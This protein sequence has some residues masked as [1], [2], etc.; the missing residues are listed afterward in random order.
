[1]LDDPPHEITQSYLDDACR[2][3]EPPDLGPLRALAETQELADAAARLSDSYGH[4]LSA[5]DPLYPLARDIA[6]SLTEAGFTLHHCARHQPLCRLGGV[7]LLPV[8]GS[9]DPDS[10]GGVVVSWTTHNLLSLDWDRWDQHHDIQ[11]VMNGALAE[12][13]D[14]LRF[15]VSPFGAGGASIV[16]SCR[17]QPGHLTAR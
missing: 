16:T 17:E 5:G 4:P 8:V 15:Q 7:C 9:Y 1:M 3:N 6:H 2:D 14:A 10:A 12:V 13:L 11:E